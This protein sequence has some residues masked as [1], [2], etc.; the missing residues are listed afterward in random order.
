MRST[1]GVLLAVLIS[2]LAQ[3]EL[4]D[5]IADRGELRIAIQA[6]NSPYAFKQ[7]DHLTGFDIEFGQAL[8]KELDLR[9]E[10]VEAPATE[11]L[12][13]VESGKYDIAL[14]PSSDSLTGDGPLDVS[15][16]IGEKKLVIPFQKDNPAFESA[17]NNALQRLKDSGRTGELEQKWFKGVQ[18]TAGGQ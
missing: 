4:I 7:D 5:E 1:I 18:E 13:G 9:A 2:P 16:P 8:A 11:V 3:A 15:R 10:F 6:D 14:T 17:V 12:A